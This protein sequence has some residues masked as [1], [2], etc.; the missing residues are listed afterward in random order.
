MTGRVVEGVSGDGVVMSCFL[1]YELDYM[2][3]YS[4]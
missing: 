3:V 1:I 2:D 4:L